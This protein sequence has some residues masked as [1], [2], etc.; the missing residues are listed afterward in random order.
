MMS[1]QHSLEEIITNLLDICLENTVSLDDLVKYLKEE[2]GRDLEKASHEAIMAAL[3][4]TELPQTDWNNYAEINWKEIAF[5]CGE[6]L[7]ICLRKEKNLL[8]SAIDRELDQLIE[9]CAFFLAAG[10]L[11]DSLRMQNHTDSDV[12][13][14]HLM[15]PFGVY[16]G[17]HGPPHIDDELEYLIRYIFKPSA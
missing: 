4:G 14:L 7:S 2:A 8:R 10:L 9:M 6:Y 16:L 15:A 1:N 3:K 13:F 5:G 11:S 12:F 17:W